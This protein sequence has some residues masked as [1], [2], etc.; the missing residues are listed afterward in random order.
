MDLET[1]LTQFSGAKKEVV[2]EG[3]VGAEAVVTVEK[4]TE[5]GTPAEE[6]EERMSGGRR[7]T[8]SSRSCLAEEEELLPQI[9]DW[10]DNSSSR[11]TTILQHLDI[12]EDILLSLPLVQE[13]R[14]LVIL[15]TINNLLVITKDIHLPQS[16]R[17]IKV[18]YQQLVL[19]KVITF[20]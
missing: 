13:C 10:A 18:Q 5:T 8:L 11:C 7:V 20:N 4:E 16:Q 12:L 15:D 1:K 6:E 19:I 14:L 9:Q 3:E 2:G 17:E